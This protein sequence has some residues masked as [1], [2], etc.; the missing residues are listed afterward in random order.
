LATEEILGRWLGTLFPN[1]F[2]LP[3]INLNRNITVGPV[4]WGQATIDEAQSIFEQW[5]KYY[6]S[7]ILAY[8]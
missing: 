6:N 7:S 3:P 1:N 5:S 2:N 8:H 4:F